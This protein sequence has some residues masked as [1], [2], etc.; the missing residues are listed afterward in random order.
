MLN[1]ICVCFRA[2]LWSDLAKIAR[3]QQV[4]DVCRVACK[5]CLLYDDNRW[6]VRTAA[7]SG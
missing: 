2:H 3:K 1:K 5:F 4:W 7:K 6:R